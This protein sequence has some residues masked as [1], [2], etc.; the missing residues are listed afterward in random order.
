MQA[1]QAKI[2]GEG[3]TYDDVLLVPAYSEVLP[4]EVSIQT[5]FTRN[6]TINV[7]IVSAAM[8]TVTESAMAI[9]IARE[10]GIGVLHKNMTIE[11][12]AQEVRKVKRAESGMII[13]PITL[14]LSA[15]VLDAKQAMR[16]HKIGGI[17]IVDEAGKL[18]GIVTNRDLRFEKNNERPIVEVMTSENLVTVAE[19]TSL[20]DAEVIL[21]ENKIEKLPVVNDDDKLVGLITFRDIT[22]LTQKPIANKDSYGR[23]R[24]AAALGVTHDAVDRAE[25]LVNAG[26]DAVIIDTAHGH[27]KGVV[28]VLKE[29]KAKFPELDVV[30]GN[31]ATPEAAKYLVEAGADAVKVGIGPGSI[32]TTRVVAGVGFPQFSAVLEVAAAIKGSG[33][34]VIADGGIRYTGDIPKAVAAGADCVMLGS[35]LAGTK[36]SPG[37]TIIYEGRKFK[38]YRGMGSVE[39]MKQGSK[40]R[41]FQDVEDDIKKLVPEGIVGRV[42]YKG[43][44]QESIHQFVGGLRAGMGYCGAKDIETLKNTGKFVRITASGINESHPHDVAI[45][46]EAPNYSRR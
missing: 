7:P 28:S 2:L 25:A 15:I 14:S 38:S 13:D 45:T 33:V 43:E 26:V 19:G 8:D 1:H 18:V 36:E 32:C 16:E 37:E 12:Q 6:I 42:A 23:L 40:D 35:L 3:L 31:I 34:P 10:G 44:L 20:K 29:V 24:V 5:K 9:A 21:Q 4:R 41:Y 17:P 46:K 27:T 30:V 39:A 11:Q 22:K